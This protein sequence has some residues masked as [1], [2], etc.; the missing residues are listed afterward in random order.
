[1]PL[2]NFTTFMGLTS[3][4]VGCV[5]FNPGRYNQDGSRIEPFDFTHLKYLLKITASVYAGLPVG[6]AL[7]HLSEYVGS[8]PIYIAMFATLAGYS[9][10]DYLAQHDDHIKETFT[11]RHSKR[12]WEKDANA[13][14]MTSV[15]SDDDNGQRNN[16]HKNH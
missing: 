4:A 1:M 8:E 7:D 15:T 6:L 9:I 16:N 13:T 10:Y 3:G 2:P 5:W 14:E 11:G 12:D